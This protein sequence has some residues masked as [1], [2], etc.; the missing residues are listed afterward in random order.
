MNE[1]LLGAHRTASLAGPLSARPAGAPA[2]L[3]DGAG[4]TGRRP[5]A[6]RRLGA[7]AA[8]CT[9]VGYIDEMPGA[10]AAADFARL[11]RRRDGDGGALA[12]GIPSILV[13]LPTAAADHQNAATRGRWPRP[14]AAL[15]CAGARA[16]AGA[17]VGGSWRSLAGD[18]DAARGDGRA[19]RASERGRTRRADRERLLDAGGRDDGA[20]AM[21]RRRAPRCRARPARA[22]ADAG[23]STSSAS[24]GRGCPRS[25]S[26]SLRS[27]G[28]VSGCDARPGA[29]A[30]RCGAWAPRSSRG[31]TPRTSTDASAV[32]TTAAV[33]ADHP[34][35]AAARARGI[36]VLKR[37]RGARRASSTAAPWSAIA[38]THGKTTTTTMTTGVLAAAGLDPTGF[39]GGARARRGAATAPGARRA[40]RGRGRRVRPLVP[41]RCSPDVAVVTTLEADH[42][43]IYGIARGGRGGVPRVRGAG[44]RATG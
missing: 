13:P 29:A 12:W 44:A 35:I 10:L 24:A 14:G 22:R 19:R 6:A 31:T 27:G 11:T 30:S 4:D 21:Q 18:A 17:A 2:P 32:V 9:R 33:P 5:G 1:A 26:C 40:L 34:E 15:L 39:V 42:L 3:G 16:D 7:V 37:A 25:P 20:W 36:P 43:D 23:R 41:D 8:G 38:G 28:R